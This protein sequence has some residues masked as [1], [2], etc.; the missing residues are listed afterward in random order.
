MRSKFTTIQHT[1]DKQSRS[2]QRPG[3]K[4]CQDSH[5]WREDGG[6]LP[7]TP[8]ITRKKTTGG[9]THTGGKYL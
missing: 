9:I 6:Y 1:H 4:K 2:C 5:E 8:S 7:Y 3:P